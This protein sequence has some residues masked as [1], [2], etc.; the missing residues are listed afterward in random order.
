VVIQHKEEEKI[1]NNVKNV[2]FKWVKGNGKV[3]VASKHLSTNSYSKVL[4]LFREV[5]ALF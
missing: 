3:N 5:I 2:L 4:M 1:Q